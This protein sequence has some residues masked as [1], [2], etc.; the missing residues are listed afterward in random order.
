MIITEV[1]EADV[2]ARQV[3]GKVNK[4]YSKPLHN[5]LTPYENINITEVN[6]AKYLNVA[7]PIYNLMDRSDNYAKTS[8][9]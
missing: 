1:A 9:N 7:M 8:G 3:D 5:L 6:N 2:T 4:K